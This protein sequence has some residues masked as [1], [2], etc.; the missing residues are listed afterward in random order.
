MPEQSLVLLIAVGAG[1]L[2]LA[3][4]IVGVAALLRSRREEPVLA[5]SPIERLAAA[6]QAGDDEAAARELVDYLRMSQERLSR[7]EAEVAALREWASRPL[8]KLG[9]VRF[10][11]ADDISGRMSCALVA[12]D[13]GDDGFILTSLYTRER[14][15]TFVR[16]VTGGRTEHE[17]LPEEAEALARA[18]KSEEVSG[19]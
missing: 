11:A 6:L 9:M 8:Q 13:A 4:L 2:A 16:R 18:L 3:A 15:R 10:D 1:V 5:G 14:C 12:L 19:G 7:L 17:L